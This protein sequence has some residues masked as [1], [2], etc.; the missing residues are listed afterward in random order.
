MNNDRRKEID[1]IKERISSLIADLSDIK[2]SIGAVR[3]EEQDALDNLP[4]SMQEGER[5]EK[6]QAA[7]DALEEA[8]SGMEDAESG[9]NDIKDNLETAKE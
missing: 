2:D 4:E 3:D 1:R 5:G 9:L 6:A 7:I 8:L